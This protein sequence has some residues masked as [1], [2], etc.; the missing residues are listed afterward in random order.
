MLQP[1]LQ[2][3]KQ[4]FRID[5]QTKP[6]MYFFS[7]EQA[8]IALTCLTYSSPF[9]RRGMMPQFTGFFSAQLRCGTG[10]PTSSTKHKSRQIQS[11]LPKWPDA[12]KLWLHF[13]VD[14]HPFA[15]YFNVHQVVQGFDP[16]PNR[17]FSQLFAPGRKMSRS[18]AA[19]RGASGTPPRCFPT[20]TRR[21]PEPTP[22]ANVAEG[23][24]GSGGRGKHSPVIPDT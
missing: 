15:A 17:R 7:L 23:E 13:G 16:Q 22:L 11:L 9:V 8:P 20:R 5:A 19:W 21:T 2:L 14:A 10:G 3:G 12:H 6:P 18:T 1:F 24:W 4:R